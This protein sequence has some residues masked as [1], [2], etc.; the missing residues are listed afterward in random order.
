M[1]KR[2][3]SQV[4]TVILIILVSLVAIGGV[5]F[6]INGLISGNFK[7][8]TTDSFTIGLELKSAK[9]NYTTGLAEVRVQRNAGEGELTGIKF[10]AEDDKNSDVFTEKFDSFPELA[11]RTFILNLSQSTILN[12]P[13]VY[14]ISIA[15]IFAIYSGGSGSGGEGEGDTQI[16]I[17]EQIGP[18]GDSI[19]GLNGTVEEVIEEVTET[20]GDDEE[21]CLI[22]SDCG[23]NE[24]LVPKFCNFDNTQVMQFQKQFTCI[25]ETFCQ[26]KTE[27]ISV[28]ICRE[29]YTCYNGSCII[30]PESCVEDSDCGTNGLIGMERCNTKHQVVQTYMEFSCKAGFC[31]SNTTDKIIQECNY[32][33]EIC[34]NGECLTQLEC[35]TNE[36]CDPG[37]VC[38]EGFCVP[39]RVINF[40][41][42]RSAW[43]FG[44]NEY[45]NSKYLPT[46]AGTIKEGY[47]IKFPYSSTQKECLVILNIKYPEIENGA[48]YIKFHKPVTNVSDDDYYE[49]WET[50]YKCPK[51][52]IPEEEPPEEEL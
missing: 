12:L 13:K 39:E 15:P 36:D 52:E 49:I 2:G 50:N 38:K 19:S 5:W 24:L 30:E 35:V 4:I 46:T 45:F 48:S 20:G 44:V 47:Y 7:K 21:G 14:R 26:E 34:Q 29:G 32:P 41:Y 17:N 9:I 22:D 11:T 1:N 3:L 16:I 42:V 8:L 43:P 31:E 27:Q 51:P 23:E 40:G 33:D 37:E 18:V 28:E 25:E 6:V 10:I